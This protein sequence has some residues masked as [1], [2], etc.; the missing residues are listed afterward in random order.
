[1]VRIFVLDSANHSPSSRFNIWYIYITFPKIDIKSIE[2]LAAQWSS[3]MIV[4]S[5]FYAWISPDLKCD[6]PRVRIPVEP[7]SFA[8]AA[9]MVLFC[10]L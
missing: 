10:M 8:C 5:G 2:K 4:A 6:R 9:C 3:G 7:F 1:M